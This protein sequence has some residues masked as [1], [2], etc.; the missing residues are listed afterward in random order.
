MTTAGEV[1]RVLPI[2]GALLAVI[3]VS[4]QVLFATV[5]AAIPVEEALLAQISKRT[6]LI[7]PPPRLGTVKRR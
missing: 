6:R 7:V 1:A 3:V 4:P 2:A 5:L